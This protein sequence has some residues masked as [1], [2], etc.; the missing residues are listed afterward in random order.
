MSKSRM[1]I[2]LFASLFSFVVG[3]GINFFLAPFVVSR[4]GGEAYGFIGLINNLISYASVLTVALNSMAGRFITMKIHQDDSKSANIYFNSVLIG[5]VIMAGIIAIMSFILLLNLGLFINIPDSLNADVKIAFSLVA[6]EFIISLASSVFGIATFVKDKLFLSSLSSIQANFLK[7]FVILLLFVIF[8]AKIFYINIASLVVTIFILT[9]NIYFTKR[10]IPEIKI[11]KKNFQINAIVELVKSGMWNILTRLSQILETGLDLLLTNIFLGASL[12]GTLSIS[13]TIP[14]CFISF[15]SI[16]VNVFAPQ[17]TIS[18][19]KNN[20]NGVIEGIRQSIK[21]MTLFT[22]LFFSF[23]IVYGRDFY[24]LWIPS[25]D[26]EFLYILTILSVFH[27]PITSGMN[28]LYNIFTITNK[29]KKSSLVLT[30]TSVLNVLIIII[31]V[32]IM[33]PK[34]SIYFIAGTSSLLALIVTLFFTMPY[35]A[36]CLKSKKVTFLPDLGICVIGNLLMAASFLIV[37]VLLGS[38][39]WVELITSLSMSGIIGI[40]INM[41]ILNNRNERILIINKILRRT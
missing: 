25:Q 17:L 14:I 30:G 22:S 7:V 40:L 38:D 4:L 9:M 5:N 18:Y 29:I 10:L 6:L 8:P 15:T 32:N 2:N 13:K 33:T 36:I 20:F 3:L 31:S 37:K 1:L 16:I 27:M 34:Y 12:M 41:I 11:S 35:A 28:S 24:K 39:T 19:A 21:I 26:S 23:I